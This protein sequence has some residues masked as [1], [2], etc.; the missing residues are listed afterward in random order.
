MLCSVISSL[1]F[2]KISCHNLSQNVLPFILACSL[3]SGFYD[4]ALFATRTSGHKRYFVYNFDKTTHS[5]LKVAYLATECCAC[6]G[7]T[8]FSFHHKLGLGENTK[9]CYTT[10]T[11]NCGF[12]FITNPPLSR[13]CQST[14]TKQY[15]EAPHFYESCQKTN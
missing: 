11:K 8:K 2:L 1:A 3:L 14:T 9:F 7:V 15:Q 12:W 13:I 4:S 10:V 5:F 6:I